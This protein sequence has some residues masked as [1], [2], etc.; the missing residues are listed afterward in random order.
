[1]KYVFTLLVAFCLLQAC[2]SD[3]ENKKSEAATAMASSVDYEVIEEA[4]APL[5][6]NKMKDFTFQTNPAVTSSNLGNG[7]YRKYLK[8]TYELRSNPV[9]KEEVV[10]ARKVC[11]DAMINLHYM[12]SKEK[13]IKELDEVLSAAILLEGELEQVKAYYAAIDA[14]IYQKTNIC[15]E[16]EG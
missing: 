12:Y 7:M 4:L 6:E 15:F 13:V 2:Q 9:Y 14:E 8:M 3:D 11:I 16:C 5:K 1:M 10:A